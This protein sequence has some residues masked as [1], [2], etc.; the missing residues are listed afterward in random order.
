MGTNGS[1]T[2]FQSD[3]LGSLGLSSHTQS[4]QKDKASADVLGLEWA[5]LQ[6]KYYGGGGSVKYVTKGSVVACDCGS[7]FT[8]IDLAE[9]HGIEVKSNHLPILTTMDF[10]SQNI[11]PFGICSKKLITATSEYAA[12]C[13][14]QIINPWMQNKNTTTDS[15]RAAVLQADA[16]A[17]CNTGGLI[18]VKEINKTPQESFMAILREQYGFDERTAKIILTLYKA[19][20]SNYSEESQWARDWRFTRLLGGLKYGL[21]G[22]EEDL[23]VMKWNATAGDWHIN[24]LKKGASGNIHNLTLK[25]YMVSTLGLSGE[26]YEYLQY[27][28]RIQ[29]AMVGENATDRKY[30]NE[31]VNPEKESYTKSQ[32]DNMK[33]GLGGTLEKTE[34]IKNWNQQCDDMCGMTDFAHQMI[35]TATILVTELNLSDLVTTTYLGGNRKRE[36]M[37]G[38]LGDATLYGKNNRPPSLGNDDYKADLDAE[39]IA[40]MV[41]N[42][43]YSFLDGFEDYYGRRLLNDN[44]AVQFLEITKLSEVKE[45]IFEELIRPILNVK[46]SVTNGYQA[47]EQLKAQYKRESFWK[48]IIKND[49][50]KDTYNFIRSLEDDLPEIG[51]FS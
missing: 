16:F 35:T 3:T 48:N 44:R 45:L 1:T 22:K 10:G 13:I 46:L 31:G 50:S 34:F 42:E 5:A 6:G 11:S 18:C 26:D 4:W 29:N 49:I 21:K 47:I 28:V 17:V 23:E 38:W 30:D 24:S 40:H 20:Q 12:K 19:I 7:L 36:Q 37:A 32:F 51:D 33:T 43:N 39:N 15:N 8:R 25:N 27:K 41:K 9:D 14:P 2:T